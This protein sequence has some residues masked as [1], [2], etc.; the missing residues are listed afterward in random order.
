MK[1]KTSVRSAL[2]VNAGFSAAS[3]LVLTLA[4]GAIGEAIGVDAQVLL[5]VFGLVLAVHAVMLL[6]VVRLPD[7]ERWAKLN[8]AAIAPYPVAMV[9]VAATVAGSGSGVALVLADGV[10]IGL[11][12]AVIAAGL[13]DRS[14]VVAHT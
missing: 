4:P 6:T 12:A 14:A 1:P 11:I 13:R 5:R 8:L 3:G 9:V 10:A 2:L 7:V